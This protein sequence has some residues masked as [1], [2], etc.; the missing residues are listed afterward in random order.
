[1]KTVLTKG[2]EIVHEVR[3]G[4]IEDACFDED[5]CIILCTVA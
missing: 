2:F 3:R 5:G 4:A 1:M